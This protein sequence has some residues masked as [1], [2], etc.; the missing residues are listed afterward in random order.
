MGCDFPVRHLFTFDVVRWQFIK[1]YPGV[2]FFK[3]H[4]LI[5]WLKTTSLLK[6]LF[7]NFLKTMLILCF[8]SLKHVRHKNW[9]QKIIESS[10][11]FRFNQFQFFWNKN[12]W[13]N[14]LLL[15]W[16]HVFTIHQHSNTMHTRTTV[17]YMWY[18][19]SVTWFGGTAP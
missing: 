5:C 6:K 2:F 13:K 9:L 10:Y 15:L 4:L 19:I 3:W 8:M 16:V 1:I 7:V 17:R 18:D 11:F 12:W 14:L